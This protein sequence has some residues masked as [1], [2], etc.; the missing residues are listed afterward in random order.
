MQKSLDKPSP[1]QTALVSESPST[2]TDESES[3]AEEKRS[4]ND[5]SYV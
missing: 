4:D 2:R 5:G 3:A 1:N